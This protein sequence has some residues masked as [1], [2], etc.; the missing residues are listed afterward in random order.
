MSN[1][2]VKDYP[3]LVKYENIPSAKNILHNLRNNL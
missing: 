1:N 3:V 2:K